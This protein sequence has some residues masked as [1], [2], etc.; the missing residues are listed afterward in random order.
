MPFWK[1]NI[2][3]Q[4]KKLLSPRSPYPLEMRDLLAYYAAYSGNSLPTFGTTYLTL[5]YLSHFITVSPES[6]LKTSTALYTLY[7][8]GLFIDISILTFTYAPY[9]LSTYATSF[10][11]CV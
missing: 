7:Y 11:R 8:I 2:S 9:S 6:Q 4:L 1:E 5:Y 10:T 3:E